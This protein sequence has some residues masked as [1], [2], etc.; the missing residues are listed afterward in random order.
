MSSPAFVEE[1][2]LDLAI[3]WAAIGGP[4]VEAIRKTFGIDF[5]GYQRRLGDVIRVHQRKSDAHS[6]A[7]LNRVYAPSVLATLQVGSL[8]V[9]SAVKGAST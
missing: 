5:D 9:D 1:D 8:G 7:E 6:R 3:I 2:I 4:T